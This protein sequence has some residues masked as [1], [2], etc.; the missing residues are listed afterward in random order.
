[1]IMLGIGI[2]TT[3]CF[4]LIIYKIIVQNKTDHKTW[5]SISMNVGSDLY[6]VRML[7]RLQ[8]LYNRLYDIRN[9]IPF[10]SD[11]ESSKM[12][13]MSQIIDNANKYLKLKIK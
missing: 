1:M 5:V 9:I 12:Y 6:T 3:T 10:L 11:I 2:I 8:R 13:K 7:I 4:W